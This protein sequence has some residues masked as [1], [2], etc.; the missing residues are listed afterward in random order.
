[1]SRE[2]YSGGSQ[3]MRGFFDQLDRMGNDIDKLL[4]SVRKIEDTLDSQQKKVDRLEE[5]VKKL[6]DKV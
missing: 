4:K 3:H 6:K 1:M 5:S 2:A